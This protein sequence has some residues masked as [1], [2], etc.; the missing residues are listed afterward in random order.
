MVF[1]LIYKKSKNDLI[2]YSKNTIEYIKQFLDLYDLNNNNII[3]FSEG[4]C[5]ILR[6]D[7]IDLILKIKQNYF[8]ICVMIKIVLMKI[9]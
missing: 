2:Q 3:D 1:S 5:M 4:N 6:K 7:V 9:G 8:T